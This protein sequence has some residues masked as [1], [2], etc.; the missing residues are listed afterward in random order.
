VPND[1][2]PPKYDAG[3]THSWDV[4]TPHQIMT[5]TYDVSTAV[6]AGPTH[7]LL[8]T[9]QDLYAAGS[10]RQGQLGL[11]DSDDRHEF[12][13]VPLPEV[14]VSL[15]VG[16][17]HSLVATAEGNVYV[18]GSNEYGQLGLDSEEEGTA[19]RQPYLSPRR[20]ITLSDRF[21]VDVAAGLHYSVALSGRGEVYVWGLNDVGQLGLGHRL[22]RPSPVRLSMLTRVTS[23]ACGISHTVLALA[24]QSVLATGSNDGG[25]LGLGDRDN[26]DVFI[27]VDFEHKS[28]CDT[29]E[30][31]NL[32]SSFMRY[33]CA[34]GPDR[35]FSSSIVKV[36]AGDSH[37]LAIASDGHVWAWGRNHHG[38]S[39]VV[40]LNVNLLHARSIFVIRVL[41]VMLAS[42]RL[43]ARSLAIARHR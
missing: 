34:G 33:V 3:A 27:R 39:S 7:T 28:A 2:V 11:G 31:A 12:T 38:L 14:A 43:P 8:S 25:Q 29:L 20:I 4:L 37:T 30:P 22:E 32:S 1:G 6:A 24:N 23:I 13:R 17:Q 10:N 15:A 36:A 35:P 40:F 5:V 16:A 41:V 26:R 21:I 9:R 18:F 42:A 19:A